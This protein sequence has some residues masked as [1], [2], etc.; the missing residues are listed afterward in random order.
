MNITPRYSVCTPGS[1]YPVQIQATGDRTTALAK[2]AEV[3]DAVVYDWS[4][5][6][7]VTA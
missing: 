7:Q 3:A 1:P 6:E 5:G 4:T 2:A